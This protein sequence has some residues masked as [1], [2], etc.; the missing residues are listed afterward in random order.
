[1]NIK[2][3]LLNPV[4]LMISISVAIIVRDIHAATLISPSVRNG[5]F[6][7]G[8]PSPWGIFL[9]GPVLFQNPNFASHGDWYARISGG[10][11]SSSS[12]FR[13]AT[14]NQFVADRN[15]GLSFNLSLD[16]R[17]GIS[18]F[19]VL[20][21]FFTVLNSDMTPASVNDQFLLFNSSNSNS[22]QQYSFQYEIPTAWT[23]GFISLGLQ[24]EKYNPV[25]GTS[26][27]GFLDN[28]VLHQVPEPSTLALLGLSARL[29]VLAR[30]KR[31]AIQR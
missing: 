15:N 13:P 4:A 14:F 20:R 11:S 26:Y 3:S 7:T 29:A 21:V 31:H 24:F 1:M 6:E 8:S 19:E 22:W 23:G 12:I 17:N 5:S 28:I 16:S 18:G 27:T 2:T 25:V 9:E 30:K 10:T